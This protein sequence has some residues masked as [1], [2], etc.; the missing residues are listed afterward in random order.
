MF[1]GDNVLGEGS[2]VFEDLGLYLSSL[3]R[4]Y[5]L[6]QQQE[7]GGGGK[8]GGGKET[9]STSGAV[10]PGHGPMARDGLALV[11]RYIE[12][13]RERVEEARRAVESYPGRTI[14][15]LTQLIYGKT[16][17]PGLIPAAQRNLLLSLNVVRC[18]L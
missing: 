12:H 2:A 6:L 10:Y 11:S 17:P 13:R 8:E 3:G 4:M 18:T 7:R 15:Q 1:A 5:D 9:E 16:T 14:S